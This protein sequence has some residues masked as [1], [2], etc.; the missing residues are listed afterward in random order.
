MS[1]IK[2]K[3]GVDRKVADT[4]STQMTADTVHSLTAILFLLGT[5]VTHIAIFQDFKGFAA[6]F[7]LT[8][9]SGLSLVGWAVA[10]VHMILLNRHVSGPPRTIAARICAPIVG[11]L[12]VA[13]L[14]IVSMSSFVR[15]SRVDILATAIHLMVSCYLNLAA[16]IASYVELHTPPKLKENNE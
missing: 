1:A 13:V 15:L 5:V 10:T 16:G 14:L 11:Q 9:G 12:S 3:E 7:E 2:K 8:F 6:P 4:D